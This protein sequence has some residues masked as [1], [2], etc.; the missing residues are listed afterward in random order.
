LKLYALPSLYRQGRLDRVRVYRADI[1]A[2]LDRYEPDLDSLLAQ[3]QPHVLES[4]LREIRS[5]VE[6]IGNESRHFQ[7]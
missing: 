3:L 4:D 5:I 1:G 6:E 2:L 7:E